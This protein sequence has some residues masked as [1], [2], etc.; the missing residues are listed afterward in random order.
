[1]WCYHIRYV[2]E[3]VTQSLHTTHTKTYKQQLYVCLCCRFLYHIFCCTFVGGVFI[4]MAT[5]ELAPP[6]AHGRLSS[7]RY[8]LAFGGGLALMY[9][10]EAVEDLAIARAFGTETNVSSVTSDLL[11]KSVQFPGSRLGGGPLADGLWA[12]ALTSSSSGG[13]RDISATLQPHGP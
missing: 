10:S 7:L 2:Q 12:A 9:L 3:Q 6:H 4:Y 8:L 5:F 13:G 11:L 1:M